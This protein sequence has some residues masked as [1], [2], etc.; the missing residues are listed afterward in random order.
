[1]RGRVW[2]AVIVLLAA[3]SGLIIDYLSSATNTP[4][5]E[6]Y[7]FILPFILG[8]IFYLI[9]LFVSEVLFSTKL[10]RRHLFRDKLRAAVEKSATVAAR[11]PA[12]VVCGLRSNVGT[13][14]NSWSSAG[15]TPKAGGRCSA[16]S[17][18]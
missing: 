18:L 9:G 16:P 8:V 11:R 2:D 10:V 5:P 14:R 15:P 13:A 7:K 17:T 1:M 12:I 6:K 4:V 3:F